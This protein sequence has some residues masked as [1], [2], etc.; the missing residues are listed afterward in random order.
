MQL[1]QLITRPGDGTNELVQYLKSLHAVEPVA[2]KTLHAVDHGGHTLLMVALKYR[3]QERATALLEH[4][5]DLRRTNNAGWNCFHWAAFVDDGKLLTL[6]AQHTLRRWSADALTEALNATTSSGKTP[7]DMASGKARAWLERCGATQGAELCGLVWGKRGPGVVGQDVP[8]QQIIEPPSEM[9]SWLGGVLDF[10]RASS[11]TSSSG[12]A[13]PRST[14]ESPLP[15]RVAQLRGQPPPRVT[16][17]PE[18]Q[19]MVAA[20]SRPAEVSWLEVMAQCA[21]VEIPTVATPARPQL[22]H[23]APPHR[24]GFWMTVVSP[25]VMPPSTHKLAPRRASLFGSKAR[26]P[27]LHRP[28]HAHKQNDAALRRRWSTARQHTVSRAGL[29]PSRPQELHTHSTACGGLCGTTHTQW[30]AP[31]S[32][33][34]G[35]HGRNGTHAARVFTS[36][37][38]LACPHT[39]LAAAHGPPCAAH[40]PSRETC[41]PSGNGSHPCVSLRVPALHSPSDT[42]VPTRARNAQVTL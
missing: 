36:R 19:S 25:L 2:T 40:P 12:R 11:P 28:S 33:R 1:H 3:K 22:R 23:I 29:A 27:H 5:S 17:W 18:L 41:T 32:R 42:A 37:H 30:V 26:V 21:R 31:R 13:T 16:S 34:G 4:G 14:A 15:A 8:W 39:A 35:F 10:A 7:K 6:L 38:P 20:V 24:L 9:R